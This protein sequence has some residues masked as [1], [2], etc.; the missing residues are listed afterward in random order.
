M[1]VYPNPTTGKTNFYSGQGG[2]GELIINN[3]QGQ[4]IANHINISS[5]FF[6]IDI[7]GPPGIYV[8]SFKYADGGLFVTK[9]VK[10]DF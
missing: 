1:V 2:K 10:Q 8:A 5:G 7:P 9:I 6:S 4:V 3:L